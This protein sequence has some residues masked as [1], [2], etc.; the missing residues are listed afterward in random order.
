[1]PLQP[2][3][4]QEYDP[5]RVK[6][7]S[8]FRYSVSVKLST[9]KQLVTLIL[10][11]LSFLCGSFNLALYPV[12]THFTPSFTLYS[13]SKNAVVNHLP[14]RIALMCNSGFNLLKWNCTTLGNRVLLRSA[15]IESFC[16][17]RNLIRI[18]FNYSLRC[19]VW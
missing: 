4:L 11:A 8:S 9:I 12:H 2:E 13:F 10:T 16:I 19:T 7:Q 17:N 18:G 5:D 14:K 6:S 1:M 3:I 15:R